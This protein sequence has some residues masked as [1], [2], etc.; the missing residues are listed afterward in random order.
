MKYALQDAILNILQQRIAYA[1]MGKE[2]GKK[3]IGSS[4]LTNNLECGTLPTTGGSS[5][6]F[7]S[8]PISN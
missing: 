4:L 3:R 1:I 5:H 7:E 8:L 6:H 2:M